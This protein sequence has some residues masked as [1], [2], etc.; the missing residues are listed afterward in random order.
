MC[1]AIPRKVLQ[2]AEDSAEVLYDGKPIW[3]KVHDI[4]D[5][6]AGE[7]LIVYAGQALERMA[8]EDAEEV[9]ESFEDIDLYFQEAIGQ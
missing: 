4:P 8:A 2:V 3:I 1:Q 7:Y 6:C 9:L 5:L